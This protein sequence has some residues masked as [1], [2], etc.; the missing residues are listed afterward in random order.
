MMKAGMVWIGGDRRRRLLSRYV[1]RF[2]G[3]G[4]RSAGPGECEDA[5]CVAPTSRGVR[6]L[7]GTVDMAQCR[8]RFR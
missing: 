7:T 8:Y 4:G 2:V 5:R 1:D 6:E 3:L